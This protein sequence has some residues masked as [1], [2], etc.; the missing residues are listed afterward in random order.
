M[1]EETLDFETQELSDEI[2]RAR[3]S[4][5]EAASTFC[6]LD[7]VTELWAALGS[8]CDATVAAGAPAPVIACAQPW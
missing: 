4:A 1:V 8:L 3:E 5:Q 2:I 6:S 7:S